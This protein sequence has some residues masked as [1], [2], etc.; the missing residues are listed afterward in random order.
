[1]SDKAEQ[2]ITLSNKNTLDIMKK[3]YI[4]PQM[5]G[6][7]MGINDSICDVLALSV[8]TTAASI[9]EGEVSLEKEL[10]IWISSDEIEL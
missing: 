2:V 5:E 10:D 1:M 4:A 8:G 6:V 7:E 3:T 9:T